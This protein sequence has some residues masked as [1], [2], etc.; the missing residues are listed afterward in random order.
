MVVDD[1]DIVGI[2][3][4]ETEADSPRAV[5]AHRPLSFAISAEPM[6]PDALERAQVSDCGGGVQNGEPF[7]CSVGVHPA[8]SSCLSALE[9]AARGR[10][11][12]RLD[13][14]TVILC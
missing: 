10:T 13:Q 6:K 12:K 5:D 14:S 2:S 3:P 8:E 11:S 1:F 4:L 9:E 7:R